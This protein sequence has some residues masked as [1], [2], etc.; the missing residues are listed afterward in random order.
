MAHGF[1]HL[2]DREKLER[3]KLVLQ[4]ESAPSTRTPPAAGQIIQRIAFERVG[5]WPGP[6]LADRD[7]DFILISASGKIS[8]PAF[9]PNLIA[10]VGR[11]QRRQV[12]AVQPHR[13]TAHRH[14][15]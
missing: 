10:I 15:P 9:V 8:Y 5:E 1:E 14:R 12:R 13:G 3:E 11:P 7:C 4:L 6:D 2:A